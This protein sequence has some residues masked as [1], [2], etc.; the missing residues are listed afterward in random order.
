M[1]VQPVLQYW[2]R[3]KLMA[4][5]V[6]SAYRTI[7]SEAVCAIA[8]MIPI[9]ITRWMIASGTVQEKPVEYGKITV[10]RKHGEFNHH[11]TQFLSGHGCL[12]KYLHRFGHAAS[13]LCPECGNVD[14]TS[15]ACGLRLPKVRDSA[16]GD[17]C[18]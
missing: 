12:R 10:N 13:P 4:M 17:A 8:G 18:P 3:S 15:C 14:E 2:K 6:V 16:K 5:R 1:E 11:R 9:G 7:S